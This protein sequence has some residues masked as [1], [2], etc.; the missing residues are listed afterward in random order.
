MNSKQYR[1]MESKVK[2]LE[3][4]LAYMLDTN[5]TSGRNCAHFAHENGKLKDTL[6]EI[7]TVRGKWHRKEI[8]DREAVEQIIELLQARHEGKN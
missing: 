5:I 4:E 1:E 6:D 8:D 2:E 3:E 7:N